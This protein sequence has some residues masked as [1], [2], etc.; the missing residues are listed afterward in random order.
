MKR[1]LTFLLLGK[2]RTRQQVNEYLTE[3]VI[4]VGVQR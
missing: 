3:D 4:E 1:R 2:P